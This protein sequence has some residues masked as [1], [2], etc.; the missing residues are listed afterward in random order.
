MNF[1]RTQTIETC[2]APR[3]ALVIY[4]P[5]RIG[6]TTL[7][8][9]FLSRQSGKRI[10]SAVGD[11]IKIRTLFRSEDRDEILTFARPY[12]ILA[13]DEAQSVENIGRG[14][15]MIIDAFPGKPLILSGSSSFDLSRQGGE[16]PPR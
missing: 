12:E 13:I 5:R 10:F 2:L 14:A 8:N 15:K 9:S 3:R 4:G 7:L 1:K 16:A 11:D 6:K